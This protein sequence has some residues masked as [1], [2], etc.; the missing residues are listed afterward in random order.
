MVVM[1]VVMMA[2]KGE[3]EAEDRPGTESVGYGGGRRARTRKNLC[4]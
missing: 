1:M 2:E 3:E 4:V